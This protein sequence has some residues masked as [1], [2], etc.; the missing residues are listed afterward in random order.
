MTVCSPCGLGRTCALTLSKRRFERCPPDEDFIHC[1]N[2]PLLLLLQTLPRISEWR[3]SPGSAAADTAADIGVKN[4]SRLTCSGTLH[5]CTSE[6]VATD[7]PDLPRPPAAAPT[8]S[9]PL[10]T[11]EFLFDKPVG[12]KRHLGA[13]SLCISLITN[14]VE[15]LSGAVYVFCS[16]RCLGL[17]EE[18]R[19]LWTLT[20]P[21][22]LEGLC[23]PALVT[24]CW[25]HNLCSRGSHTISS[26]RLTIPSLTLLA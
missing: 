2:K 10:A 19:T 20:F 23:P 6:A 4:V 9:P 1:V 11:S 26:Y 14:K 24:T 3:A 17:T 13:I 15:H 5:T 21:R 16:V 25:P 18:P 12:V 7:V 22:G 8:S